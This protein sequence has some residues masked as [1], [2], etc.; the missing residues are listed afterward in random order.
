MTLR[1]SFG[2]LAVITFSTIVFGQPAAAVVCDLNTCINNCQSRRPSAGAGQ[3][4]NSKCMIALE[5]RKKK[6]QCK[7]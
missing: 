5:E 6:G 7:R 1:L 3:V 4:C 2:F